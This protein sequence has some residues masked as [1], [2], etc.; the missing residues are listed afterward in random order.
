MAIGL[1]LGIDSLHHCHSAMM[2]LTMTHGLVRHPEER[3]DEGSPCIA[4]NP[5]SVIAR[6]VGL[7]GQIGRSNLL[8]CP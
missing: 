5:E 2:P 3:S 7:K 6:P 1:P 8:P 4:E